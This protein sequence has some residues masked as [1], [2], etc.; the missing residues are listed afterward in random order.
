[1]TPGM[2]LAVGK[3]EIITNFSAKTKACFCKLLYWEKKQF[4]YTHTHIYISAFIVV[5]LVSSWCSTDK[6]T[7]GCTKLCPITCSSYIMYVTVY[8]GQRWGHSFYLGLKDGF[9]LYF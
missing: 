6:M 8:E 3:V 4:V 1:M 7:V 2:R 9:K 5:L